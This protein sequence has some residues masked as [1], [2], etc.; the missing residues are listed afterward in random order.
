[1]PSYL[2]TACSSAVLSLVKSWSMLRPETRLTA[3]ARSAGAMCL[4][5]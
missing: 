4:L 5:M 1:M 2:L 3:A